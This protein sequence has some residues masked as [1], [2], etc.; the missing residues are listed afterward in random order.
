MWWDGYL[1]PLAMW[2]DT[3]NGAILVSKK[4]WCNFYHLLSPLCTANLS[5]HISALT[6]LERGD[7]GRLMTQATTRKSEGMIRERVK[8]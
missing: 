1:L 2:E 7:I 4:K 5:T 8:A 3:L 6:D